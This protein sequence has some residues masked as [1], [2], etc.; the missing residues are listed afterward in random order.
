MR[1]TLARRAKQVA[2]NFEI[3]TSS[4]M[5]VQFN[6][7]GH[8][9]W[10]MRYSSLN[11]LTRVPI[12]ALKIDQSFIRDIT[13]DADPAA[14]VRAII[15][16]AKSLRLTVVAEGVETEAQL[17]VLRGYGCDEIQ[18][19]VI[20]PR[21]AP[22]AFAEFLGAART[23]RWGSCAAPAFRGAEP[24]CGCHDFMAYFVPCHP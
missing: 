15:A 19:H 21:L 9:L 13:T 18:G 4:G 6:Y 16:P 12:S 22:A 1:F 7:H 8:G 11:Y 24:S 17:D 10:S 23:P 14:I 2:L 3:V 5:A 20:S